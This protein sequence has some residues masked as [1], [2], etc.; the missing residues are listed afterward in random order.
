MQNILKACES[1]LVLI[2]VLDPIGYSKKYAPIEH[3]DLFAERLIDW[4]PTQV[5]GIEAIP[6]CAA[7]VD[8][9]SV[10]TNWAPCTSTSTFPD[11][12]DDDKLFTPYALWL[13]TV[14]GHMPDVY[15]GED[16]TQRWK[17]ESDTKPKGGCDTVVLADEDASDVSGPRMI[18]GASILAQSLAV[19][20]LMAR[21]KDKVLGA[22]GTVKVS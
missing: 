3:V 16:T 2:Y 15:C 7:T 14:G 9:S 21:H 22:L 8:V 6:L 12:R 5:E 13:L 20:W 4:L 17:F 18:A 11:P 19:K 1:S 10:G